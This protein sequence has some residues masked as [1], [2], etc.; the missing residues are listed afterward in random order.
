MSKDNKSDSNSNIIEFPTPEGHKWLHRLRTVDIKKFSASATLASVLLIVPLFNGAYI[1][2]SQDETEMTTQERGVASFGAVNIPGP[3]PVSEEL[4]RKLASDTVSTLKAVG[5]RPKDVEKFQVE[6]L[7]GKYNIL[8]TNDSLD[9]VSKI[10]L[11]KENMS[12]TKIE[13]SLAFLQ[14]NKNLW[15]V[16][17]DGTEKLGDFV[18]GNKRSEIYSLKNR[19]DEVIGKATVLTDVSGG[20]ISLTIQKQ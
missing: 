16:Q 6:T 14:S 7:G 10:E 12:P 17:F 20:M 2:M 18:M 19:S 13:D 15:S 9:K 1:S 4:L 11:R 5:K 8:S 3:E